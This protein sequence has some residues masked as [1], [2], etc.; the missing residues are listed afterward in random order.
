[1][2]RQ[3]SSRR[4]RW[5]SRSARCAS[6]QCHACATTTP[7]AQLDGNGIASAVPASALTPEGR[8]ALIS[9]TG[10]IAVTR[11]P[12]IRRQRVILPVPAASS[13]TSRPACWATKST[14]AAG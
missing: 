1:M 13:T 14:T 6:N 4:T 10:S 2:I 5:I 8:A 11:I 12:A 7:S 9:S 3:P